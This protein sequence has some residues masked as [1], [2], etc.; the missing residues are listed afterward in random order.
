M[1]E[2]EKTMM[3][4][5]T[6]ILHSVDKYVDPKGNRFFIAFYYSDTWREDASKALSLGTLFTG[7]CLWEY[8][9]ACYILCTANVDVVREDHLASFN[10]SM[11][12]CAGENNYRPLNPERRRYP[13]E[14]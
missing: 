2:V 11:K 13:Q 5:T 12:S 14:K 6:D 9:A 3:G 10:R 4:E 7:T 1:L 8:W